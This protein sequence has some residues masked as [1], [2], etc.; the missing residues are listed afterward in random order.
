MAA[1]LR[2]RASIRRV[3]RRSGGLTTPTFSGFAG[4]GVIN[5]TLRMQIF[6]LYLPLQRAIY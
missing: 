4:F 6:R 5:T 1:A 2:I 3:T